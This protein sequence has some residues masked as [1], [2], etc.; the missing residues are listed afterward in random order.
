MNNRIK[1]IRTDIGLT[2]EEFGEKILLKPNSVSQIE[3][4]NRNPSDHVINMICNQFNVNE[5]WLRT[6]VGD[7]YVQKTR[8]DEI[9]EFFSDV[10]SDDT[11]F[12]NRLIHVLA[13]YTD[14]EWALLDKMFDKF[15]D[16]LKKE[17]D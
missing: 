17:E 9:A 14:D 5:V 12:K 10:L 4:G 1:K 8:E 2:Q 7:P 3:S 13:S 15:I 6:G 11:T 16:E